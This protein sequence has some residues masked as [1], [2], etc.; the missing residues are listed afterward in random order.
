MTPKTR[1]K[2]DNFRPINDN[3]F[4]TELDSGP[5]KTAGGI[6][7]PDDNMTDRGIRCRWGQV[8]CVGPDVT[9]IT[10][11]DWVLIEH[12]R[13]TTAIELE[14][15]SG[16]VRMWRV[17]WPAAVLIACDTDPR[18]HRTT[19]LPDVHHPQSKHDLVRSKAPFIH[20]FH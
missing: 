17:D 20:R 12:G 11:G 6:L 14:L 15:P 18:E 13:W 2:A 9:D 3:V 8:W 1:I 10:P 7:L 5:H 19:T 4:V 16:V